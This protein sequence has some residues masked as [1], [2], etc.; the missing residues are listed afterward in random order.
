MFGRHHREQPGH[1]G[2]VRHITRHHLHPS[3]VTSQL[4]NQLRHP[5]RLPTTAAGQ[6][7][8]PHPP[9]HHQIPG[10]HPRQPATTTSDQHRPIPHPPRRHQTHPRPR[11][12]QP[13]HPRQPTTDHPLRL[14][15]QPPT[16]NH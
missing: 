13:A 5:R 16:Q 2:P 15:P 8:T 9:L 1:R 6:H 11:R 4:L 12:H 7:Q 10:Y 14:P 3:P